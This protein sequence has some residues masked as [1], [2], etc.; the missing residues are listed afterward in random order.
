MKKL[1]VKLIGLKLDLSTVEQI[2][3]IMRTLKIR[4]YTEVIKHCMFS[5]VS[6]NQYYQYSKTISL[7]GDNEQQS[8]KDVN[9]LK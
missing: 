2:E 6:L 5:D 4:T 8:N 9:N 7:V 3:F 1:K